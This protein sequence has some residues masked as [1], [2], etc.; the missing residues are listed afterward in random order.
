MGHAS[1]NMVKEIYGRVREGARRQ[2]RLT[3][4]AYPLTRLQAGAVQLHTA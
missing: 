1:E 3:T 2:V 4:L